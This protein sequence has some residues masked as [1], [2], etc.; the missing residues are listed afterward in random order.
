MTKHAGVIASL[1]LVMTA[2]VSYAQ[3]TLPYSGSS[4][5]T[6]GASFEVTNNVSGSSV[7]A[8]IRAFAN[9]STQATAVHASADNGYAVSASSLN[10]W[11][12]ESY[13]GPPL[14]YSAT[15]YCRAGRFATG[16]YLPNAIALA[17]GSAEGTGVLAESGD[18]NAIRANSTAGIGIH[19]TSNTFLGVDAESVYSAAI[20][21]RTSSTVSPS[22][23][24][25]HYGA[26]PAVFGYNT[27]SGAS[28]SGVWGQSSTTHATVGAGSATMAAGVHGFTA[29]TQGIGVYAEGEEDGFG[30]YAV[31]NN[32]A[33]GWAAYIDGDLMA[34]GVVNGSAKAFHIDHPADPQN[35][36]LT[37]ISVESDSYKNIYDGTTTVSANG[38]AVVQLPTWFD[39]L[40]KDFRYQ[41]TAIGAPG[42]LYVKREI[43]GRE[44]V[45][46]GPA[47]LKV[48]WQVT[49][50]RK[51][52]FALQHPLVVEKSK[53]QHLKGKYLSASSFPGGQ[54]YYRPKSRGTVSNVVPPAPVAAPAY[55]ARYPARQ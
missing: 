34:T 5:T 3:L 41:L 29:S 42:Q 30:L 39:A 27:G 4:T 53:P 22:I 7:G 49:G 52:A 14:T 43:S 31:L 13:C 20:R 10:N 16:N 19:A 55:E 50:V 2:N 8:A 26:Q 32:P 1:A 15:N 11:A 48:S 23:E 54:G 45:I 9:N 40:N 6:P 24:G 44:F 47:G 18:G 17:A 12:V 25:W 36:T 33:T 35:K 21:S 46:G 28:A 51:D 37:H 38:E